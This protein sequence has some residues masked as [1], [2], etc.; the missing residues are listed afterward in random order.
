MTPSNTLYAHALLSLILKIACRH[1]L[2]S[3]CSWG[4]VQSL[5][6]G[7]MPQ[8]ATVQRLGCGGRIAYYTLGAAVDYKLPD[9][10]TSILHHS[11][12]LLSVTAA[13]DSDQDAA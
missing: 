9:S 10:P 6:D 8:G 3:A 11:A 13:S 4:A 5:P 7:Y 2:F 1:L 12:S